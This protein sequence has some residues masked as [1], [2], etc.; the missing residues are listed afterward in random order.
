M[1]AHTNC[2]NKIKTG[3]AQRTSSRCLHLINDHKVPLGGKKSNTKILGNH[4]ESLTQRNKL[5]KQTETQKDEKS[6]LE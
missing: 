5:L 4:N 2:K 6:E 1:N 3:K